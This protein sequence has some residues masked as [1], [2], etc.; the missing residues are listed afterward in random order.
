MNKC[1]HCG[2]VNPDKVS[3]CIN[4]GKSMFS[5][6]EREK[7]VDTV[8]MKRRCYL[9]KDITKIKK[10]PMLVILIIYGIFFLW[11]SCGD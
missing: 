6:G 3:I 4:C 2:F 7:K 11:F 1:P 9:K 8:C 5:S 10:I